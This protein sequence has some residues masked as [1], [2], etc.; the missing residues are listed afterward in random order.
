MSLPSNTAPLSQRPA[1]S[2][3]RNTPK[4]SRRHLE[5]N[6]EEAHQE[7]LQQAKRHHARIYDLALLTLESY[8]LDQLKAENELA[9]QRVLQA[10]KAAAEAAK[11]RELA[12]RT[13][14]AEAK[15]AE[16]LKEQAVVDAQKAKTLQEQAAAA[17]ASQASQASATA[18]EEELKAKRTS[19]P[20]DSHDGQSS[21]ETT[22]SKAAETTTSHPSTTSQSSNPLTNG[23]NSLKSTSPHTQNGV[24]TQAPSISQPPFSTQT[25]TSTLSPGQPA[26]NRYLDPDESRLVT[27]HQNCK[28]MRAYMKSLCD[29]HKKLKTD[30]G[31]SRRLLRMSVGQLTGGES[32]QKANQFQVEKVSK[33]LK[34]ALENKVC[35]SP[36]MS[37]DEFVVE[38]RQPVDGAHNNDQL[39]VMFVWLL[40]HF[41]KAVI[42]QLAL[43]AGSTPLVALSVAIFTVRI[44][45][46]PEFLWR[47]KSLIDILIAKFR[48]VCP[49]LFGL[50]LDD[51]TEEGR[52]RLGWKKNEGKWMSEEQ[53]VGRWSGIVAGYAAICLRDFSRST[54]LKHPYGVWHYWKAIAAIASTPPAELT[55]TQAY[56]L[57]SLINNYEKKFVGF[58]GSAAIA[59]LRKATVEL[60]SKIEHQNEATR[61]LGALATKMNHELGINVQRTFTI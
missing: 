37:M 52:A 58:Y 31:M 32:D 14:A 10:E 40:N 21:T 25:P 4:S 1:N 17:A 55:K 42:N 24:A 6:S 53:Q 18:A 5:R 9:E 34:D 33:I 22:A 3:R 30:S 41:A 61:A 19:P 2:P 35:P 56:I 7:A 13:A 44:F 8:N 28:K 46:Q 23:F 39:P 11:A 45:S 49:P 20:P 27:I 50:R 16:Q 51:T 26:P 60:P 54:K 12:Q 36:M 38:Q 48:I 59:V 29:Q 43:E 47:G 15:K 57:K